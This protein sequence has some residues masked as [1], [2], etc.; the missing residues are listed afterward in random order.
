MVEVVSVLCYLP[1]SFR[2]HFLRD[3]RVILAV[4]AGS[5]DHF[6]AI[7]DGPALAM[8]GL[9]LIFLELKLGLTFRD[10]T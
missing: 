2:T 3:F 6:F 1:T 9:A 10:A 5:L 4:G 8:A 7:T